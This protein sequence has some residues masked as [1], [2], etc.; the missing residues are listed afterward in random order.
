MKNGAKFRVEWRCTECGCEYAGYAWF[1]GTA[2]KMALL[3]EDCETALL[4]DGDEALPEWNLVHV[5]LWRCV[6]YAGLRRAC[7]RIQ[8][9]NGPAARRAFMNMA[10]SMIVWRRPQREVRE[11]PARPPRGPRQTPGTVYLIS[12]GEC[13]KIGRTSKAPESRLAAL[14][15][16]SARRLSLVACINSAN[17]ADAEKALHRQFRA[18][19]LIN[20]WFS[21]CQEIRSA[22]MVTA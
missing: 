14:Q 15:T 4:G 13:L 21:D 8:G 20:E 11:M 17:A 6:S 18:R 16:A 1:H 3:C 5:A 19:R 2:G 7:W 12:D 22:F 9:F 10:R